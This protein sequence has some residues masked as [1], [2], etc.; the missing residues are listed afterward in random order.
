VQ[1]RIGHIKSILAP[2]AK[3]SK[4]SINR[5][6]KNL[7]W[8]LCQ[9]TAPLRLWPNFIIIGAQKC[10]TSSLYQYLI[11]HPY[12]LSARKKEIHYFD[13]VAYQLG[14]NWY[15]AHFRLPTAKYLTESHDRS[16]VIT[17]EASPYYLAYPLAPE[18]IAR[19]LP[20]VKLIVMLRNPIDRAFSHYY[21]QVRKGRETLSFENAIEAE[22]E[23]LQGEIEKILRDEN[24]Y[25]YN[26]WAYSYLTRGLYIE[27]LEMW[28]KYFSR[29]QLFILNSE[30]FFSNPETELNRTLEFLQLPNHKL[31]SYS[32][33]N[34]GSYDKMMV[35]T[36]H[37]LGEFFQPYN[38]QL[39]DFVGRNY[40]WDN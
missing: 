16:A 17:G 24:Y 2:L 25:S 6:S 32:K 31:Q 22:E 21:H 38:Q 34:A 13:D 33:V 27:Q 19:I 10:G 39:Y 20:T 14:I 23:R 28:M 5:V 8:K 11:Q 4:Q 7:E 26:F 12:I 30:E 29:D 18:R 37:K 1:N 9:W 3:G 35:R 36:R 40:G 15:R